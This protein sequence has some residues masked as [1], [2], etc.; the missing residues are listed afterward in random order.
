MLPVVPQPLAIRGKKMPLP[1]LLWGGKGGKV[2]GEQ[3]G[4]FFF[5]SLS[6]FSA[7]MANVTRIAMVPAAVKR[8]W[9]VWLRR[10]RRRWRWCTQNDWYICP[11]KLQ[12]HQH[13]HVAHQPDAQESRGLSPLARRQPRVQAAAE[14]CAARLHFS[15]RFP[16]KWA[17]I[18]RALS[19]H[20][21]YI[22]ACVPEGK[23]LTLSSNPMTSALISSAVDRPL[24][25]SFAV[26][27]L[28][29]DTNLIFLHQPPRKSTTS[30]STTCV[31]HSAAP[32]A[33][34]AS[35]ARW[36]THD[37]DGWVTH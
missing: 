14:I 5:F 16:R 22:P 35:A 6:L 27:V 18:Y 17:F 3:T 24:P 25:L 10:R 37:D 12:I 7:Y 26:C 4:L 36:G 30:A 20:G 19:L 33:H 8:E 11:G 13:I 29:A 1:R 21:Y 32:I 9:W 28:V 2:G 31:C 34:Q 23:A 15:R